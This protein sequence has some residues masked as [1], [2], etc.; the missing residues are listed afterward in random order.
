MYVLQNIFNAEKRVFSK[1]FFSN[2]QPFSHN[3][4]KKWKYITIICP[5]IQG[6]MKV[7]ADSIY[8]DSTRQASK[9]GQ[10]WLRNPW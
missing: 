9:I 7:T 5:W 1:I 4:V 2:K 8:S 3:S 10:I 6:H